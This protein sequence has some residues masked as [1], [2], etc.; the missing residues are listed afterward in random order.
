LQ[1]YKKTLIK[2]VR[3][4]FRQVTVKPEGWQEKRTHNGSSHFGENAISG[5]AARPRMVPKKKKKRSGM[6]TPETG[7]R[8]G[9]QIPKGPLK[10]KCCIRV[11]ALDKQR[12]GGGKHKFHP[13]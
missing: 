1:P 10:R 5:S 3:E 11:V 9:G 7:G 4:R 2:K 6:G 12:R 13:P 8:E